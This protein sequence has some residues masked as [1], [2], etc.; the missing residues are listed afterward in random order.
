MRSFSLRRP[1]QNIVGELPALHQQTCSFDVPSQKLAELF[2]QAE[3]QMRKLVSQQGISE[4]SRAAVGI[5]IKAQQPTYHP[6]LSSGSLQ[7][8]SESE[9]LDNVAVDAEE[10]KKADP[11]HVLTG[12]RNE[13]ARALWRQQLR[14]VPGAY[15][16]PRVNKIIEILKSH[17]NK[18]PDNKQVI[19]DESACFL[20]AVQ[21][22]RSQTVAQKSRCPFNLTAKFPPTSAQEYY[23]TLPNHLECAN[24]LIQCGP[25][26]KYSWE[27][28]AIKRFHRPGQL[29]EVWHY[30]VIGSRA[31]DPWMVVWHSSKRSFTTMLEKAL[32]LETGKSFI[33]DPIRPERTGYSSKSVAE[34]QRRR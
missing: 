15:Y 31:A 23:Q 17:H 6:G 21:V 24:V 20:D 2:S 10:V 12:H 5:M 16:S 13:A 26:W 19:M 28:Q 30:K 14:E 7:K 11:N 33:L 9:I 25:W 1:I 29:K 27:L 32:T 18:H 4:Q 22:A 3:K 8:A 34:W